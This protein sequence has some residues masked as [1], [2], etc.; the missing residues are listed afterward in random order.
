VI[1]AGSA[2]R[3]AFADVQACGARPVA[4]GAL[5][6]LGS[7]ALAF[8]DQAGVPLETLAHLANR[9]WEPS[10]CPLCASGAP[11]EGVAEPSA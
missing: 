4:V 1:N 5:L 10:A 7:P 3:G 2:V 11:L 6:T 9:L 8:A